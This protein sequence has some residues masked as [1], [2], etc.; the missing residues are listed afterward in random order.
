V[1][2][3]CKLGVMFLA[4]MGAT[5]QEAAINSYTQTNLDSDIPGL[6]SM[7]ER[8]LVN[9]W[10]LS[11]PSLRTAGDAYWWAADQHT[12][13]STLYDANGSI[14][15]LAVTI[16][17]AS[18]TGPG[19]PAGTVFF[20]KNFVFATLDGT[21]SQWFAGASP[22]HRGTGCTTCHTT[23]AT[24]MVNHSGAGAVYTGITLGSN[25]GVETYYLAN[26]AGGVEAY[27]TS[28]NPV[29]LTPGAFVDPKL[30]AGSTL[31]GIQSVGDRIYVTFL[32]PSPATGGY[33]DA[34]DPTGKLLLRLQNGSWFDEP[35]G[36]ARAPSN[37]GV[38]SNALLVG[39]TGSGEIAAFNA[40]TG[41]YLGVLENSTGT[42]ITNA[43]LWAIYF[44]SGNSDSG[45]TNT[46]YFS[47]GIQQYA[48][49]LFGSIT[50]K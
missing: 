27:D 50:A 44:G 12:G 41:K 8:L 21:I 16:P 3:V 28:Y 2:N 1:K 47:A 19:S 32:P 49:G 35:W 26:S 10:G 40:L 17:P 15:P 48:H 11:R 22:S 33:V 4:V 18:G 24:I 34:F 31:F 5:A 23:S 42:A 25:S 7:T 46:L 45:P 6:A 29:T 37:F 30:P 38:F 9:P 43:G 39:N 20:Q 13:V 14:L 36:I